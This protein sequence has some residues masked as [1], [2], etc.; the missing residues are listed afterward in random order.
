MLRELVLNE[1][2][3]KQEKFVVIVQVNDSLHETSVE[4][5]FGFFF[6]DKQQNCIPES[7]QEW[8]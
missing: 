7:E 5:W 8:V 6:L 3:I 1:C 4:V 2:V